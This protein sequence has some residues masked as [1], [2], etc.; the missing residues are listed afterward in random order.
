MVPKP[1]QQ[2]V[3]L[4]TYKKACET[5][6]ESERKQFITENKEVENQL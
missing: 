6:S 2:A 3:P 1:K 5:A 4:K